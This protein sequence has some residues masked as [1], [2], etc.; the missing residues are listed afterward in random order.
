MVEVTAPVATC[1]ADFS[2]VSSGK[3]VKLNSINSQSSPG[4]IIS[5]RWQF[6]DGKVLEGN[7]KDPSH[8]YSNQGTYE[9]CLTIK[10]SAGCES[11]QCK[12]VVIVAAT[13]PV[14]QCAAKFSYENL[15]TKKIRFNSGNSVA[16]SNSTVI[17]RKWD[18]GDGTQLG[19]NEINPAKEYARP[20]IY[21]VCLQI[22]TS[23]KCENRICTTIHIEDGSTPQTASG[24]HIKKARSNC[25]EPSFCIPQYV[26]KIV[27][28][29][30]DCNHIYVWFLFSIHFN[31]YMDFRSYIGIINNNKNPALIR[32]FYCDAAT[33]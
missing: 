4:D 12:S 17:E 24:D 18:F 3:T 21:T 26:N 23:D 29:I 14:N 27:T 7:I 28:I 20:G 33:A 19:G 8:E 5:R 31:L 9:V 32:V 10:T 30:S 13:S 1:K 16:N 6:G 15:S 22:R 25:C 2:L 11:K